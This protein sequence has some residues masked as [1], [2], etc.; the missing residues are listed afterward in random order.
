[1]VV[2]GSASLF[3]FDREVKE[4]IIENGEESV[5]EGVLSS[6]DG[7]T[8][9]QVENESYEVLRS[10]RMFSYKDGDSAELEGYVYESKVLPTKITIGGEEIEIKRKEG[11]RGKKGNRG[12]S[13]ER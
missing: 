8:Y 12:G 5:L 3:S 9:I 6:K 11:P 4:N 2:I 13:R 1:M 10:P 7:G